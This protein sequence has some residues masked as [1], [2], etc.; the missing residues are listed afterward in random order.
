MRQSKG[1]ALLAVMGLLV[2][3]AGCGNGEDENAKAPG[4]PEP[5]PAKPG[6]SGPGPRWDVSRRPQ[7]PEGVKGASVRPAAVAGAFYP[8][9]AEALRRDV[10][11]RLAAAPGPPELPGKLRAL[12]VPHA[13]YRY[14]GDTA[15]AAYKIVEGR[16]FDRVVLLGPAHRYRLRGVSIAGATYYRTPLGEVA[17]DAAFAVR[18]RKAAEAEAVPEAHAREHSLEV[19]LPFLQVAIGPGV[20]IVPVL[21]GDDPAAQARL[22]V[23]LAGML[24]ERTLLVVSTDLSHYPP[25]AVARKVDAATV[26]SWKTL[27]LGKVETVEREQMAAGHRNLDCTMCGG[28]AVRVLMRLAP[29]AGIDA[30]RVL[31]LDTSATAGGEP[32]RVVGYAAVAFCASGREK[33]ARSSAPPKLSAASRRRLLEIARASAAAMAA[34]RGLPGLDLAG[35][36]A[37]LAKP[38]GAFVT[39]RNRDRLRGCIGRY[40]GEASIAEVVHR[41]AA[42][43]ARDSRFRLNPVT[44]EEVAKEIDIEISVLSPL[45]RLDDWRKIRLGAHGVILRRGRRSGVFLPQVATETGWTLEE[46]LVHLARDKA[47]LAPD[48]YKDPATEVLVFTA[49]VFGEKEEGAGGE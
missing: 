37:E 39:L 6:E 21:A 17:V 5:K 27:D 28:A 33:P 45:R 47:G 15:A 31:K 12:V 42:A 23:A 35:L 43:A 11:A 9:E 49:L 22:A 16:G 44:P 1:M 8:G 13:G 34:G 26:E 36:P 41:M 3:A 38:G 40:P 19:Q 29:L 48:A 10:T 7:L 14:S 30:V 46:F 24:D 4:K 18:L 20:R 25:L 2:A 32:G